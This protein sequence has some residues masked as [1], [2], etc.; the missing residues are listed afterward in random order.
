M[1]ATTE[2]A[3]PD[4]TEARE[5]REIADHAKRYAAD[6]RTRAAE[7]RREQVAGLIDRLHRRERFDDPLEAH[8]V[9]KLYLA[10][11][12]ESEIEAALRFEHAAAAL[13]ETR[14]Q[15]SRL[16]AR[17]AS[18][19]NHIASEREIWARPGEGREA[20]P[21]LAGRIEQ[22]RQA[23]ADAQAEAEARRQ[24]LASRREA[25]LARVADWT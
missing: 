12:I 5:A 15:L 21:A 10:G 19:N 1:T 17:R 20:D 4:T 3:A 24:E 25:I 14:R 13:A 18:P 11:D 22:A 8:N 6:L 23:V 16:E 7:A 9:L 2:P